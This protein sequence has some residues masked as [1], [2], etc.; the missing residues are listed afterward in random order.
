MTEAW[1]LVPVKPTEEMLATTEQVEARRAK[2]GFREKE[3]LAWGY[4]L[5]IKAA[6]EPDDAVVE[7]VARALWNQMKLETDAVGHVDPK[8]EQ[9]PED[10]QVKKQFR[11]NARA[12]INAM[13]ENS[14][15]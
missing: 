1:K 15:G 3:H 4:L 12:V 11:A 5:M 10:W 8:W 7:R 9:V 14:D 13:S 6:P 2:A